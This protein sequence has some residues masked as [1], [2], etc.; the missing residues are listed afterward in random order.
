ML[1]RKTTLVNSVINSKKLCQIA[2][3]LVGIQCALFSA[4]VQAETGDKWEH[5][6]APLFLWGMSV[7][8]TSEINGRAADLD[9]N[10]EDDILE[11][12]EAAIT[13]HYEARKGKVVLFAEYQYVELNPEISSEAG[14]FEVSADIDFT[15][16][17]LELGLGYAVWRDEDTLWEML[18]GI[19]VTDHDL[20]VDIDAKIEIPLPNPIEREFSGN[21]DGG[22]DWMHPFLGL[23]LIQNFTD[24]WSLVLRGDAALG[25]FDNK[26][27]HIN[28]LVD[29][30]FNKWGSVFGGYRHMDYDYESSGYAYDASQRGPMLG[31]AFYW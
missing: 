21:L 12:M 29:Y 4:G 24:K 17:M 9:L 2:A 30:R 7:D 19:R 16:Q 5:S 20:D 13:L 27:W 10:F 1:D 6:L 23:R 25:G 14:P 26:A 8:G 18:G 31:L 28:A 11:N 15:I 22:D 3:L